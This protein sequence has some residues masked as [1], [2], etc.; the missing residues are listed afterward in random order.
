MKRKS[1]QTA[2]LATVSLH[3]RAADEDVPLQ[4][5]RRPPR[6]AGNPCRGARKGSGAEQGAGGNG[7]RTR[8]GVDGTLLRQGHAHAGRHPLGSENRPRQP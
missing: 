6:R 7:R 8:R 5:Q 1:L 2:L 4:G 3:R